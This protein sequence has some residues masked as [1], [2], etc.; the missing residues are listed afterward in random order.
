MWRLLLGF[1]IGL[2]FG[3]YYDFK[4]SMNKITKYI[5]DNLPEKK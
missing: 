5:K 4:P 2:Y 1:G 3:T